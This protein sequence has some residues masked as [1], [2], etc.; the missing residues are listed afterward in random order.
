MWAHPFLGGGIDSASY[1][2]AAGD[3]V[4]FVFGMAAPIFA[5]SPRLGFQPRC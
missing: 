1:I 2:N 5:I 4:S 3:L